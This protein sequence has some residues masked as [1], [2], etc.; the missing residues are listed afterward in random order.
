MQIMKAT[1]AAVLLMGMLLNPVTSHA[2]TTEKGSLSFSVGYLQQSD[3]RSRDMLGD[4]G[5]TGISLNN[6]TRDTVFKLGY[7]RP[8]TPEWGIAMAYVDLGSIN[9]TPQLTLPTGKTDTQAAQDIVDSLPLRGRGFTVKS[10]RHFI[11]SPSMHLQLNGGVSLL[12]DQ[13]SATVGTSRI[14]DEPLSFGFVGG[15]EAAY[16]LSQH[17]HLILDWEHYVQQRNDIDVMSLGVRYLF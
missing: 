5:Y 16:R 11:L 9:L 8:I 14:S 13:L 6:D 12:S 4:L 17:T 1:K 2:M 15:I 7:H 3:R 10:T